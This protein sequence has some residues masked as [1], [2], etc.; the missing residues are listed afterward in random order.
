MSFLVATP[1]QVVNVFAFNIT[2]RSLSLQ[3]V[4]P[5][6][7]N[8][9]VQYYMV[10]FMDPAFVNEERTRIVNSTVEMADIEALYPGI[11]YSFTVVAANEIGRSIPSLPLVVRT[12]N[13]GGMICNT[14]TFF[15]LVYVDIDINILL[16][17]YV[18]PANIF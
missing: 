5:H 14:F 17:T 18:A 6:S 15:K 3:W 7:N 8:G 9:P 2:S 11:D 4:E 10:M 12:S 16:C 13:E 1:L